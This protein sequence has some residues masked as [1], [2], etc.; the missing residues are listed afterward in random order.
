MHYLLL[1]ANDYQSSLQAPIVIPDLADVSSGL[2]VFRQDDVIDLLSR[3][4]P[5]GVWKHDAQYGNGDVHL[6]HGLVGPSVTIPL[7]EG[8][9]QA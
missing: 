2:S 5:M 4:I 7:I 3:Q 6:K 8:R 9:G 1:F